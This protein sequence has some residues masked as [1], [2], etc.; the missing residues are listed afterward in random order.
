MIRNKLS[1]E[2]ISQL[3]SASKIKLENPDFEDSVIQK[4]REIMTAR[5]SKPRSYNWIS[6]ISYSIGLL[7]GVIFSNIVYQSG[8][9]IPGIKPISIYSILIIGFVLVGY[10]VVQ[11]SRSRN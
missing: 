7:T 4:T 1:D 2:N 3:I 9:E 6:I 8:I 5:N 10:R 11:L